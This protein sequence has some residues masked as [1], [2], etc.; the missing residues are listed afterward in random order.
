ML[1]GGAILPPAET[2]IV[3]DELLLP[4]GPLPPPVEG[5]LAASEE[6]LP[7]PLL[8]GA[9]LFGAGALNF[10]GLISKIAGIPKRKDFAA[11]PAETLLVEDELLL[12]LPEEAP[13][14][15]FGE[16]VNP[17]FPDEVLEGESKAR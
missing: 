16:G 7:P 1:L 12:L 14:L 15:L 13:L 17:R 3:E 10:G 11:L 6:V 5:G 8:V 9:E 2:L 4:E